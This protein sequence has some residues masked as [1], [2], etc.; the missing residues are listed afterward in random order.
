MGS[1]S[2]MTALE[3]QAVVSSLNPS[4]T[5]PAPLAV[6]TP[7]Q[8][9]NV[10]GAS[11][12]STNCAGC[13]R[14]LG[15]STKV[16]MT[17]ARL[18][19]ATNNNIGG[20]GYLSQLTVTQQ[21][22]IVAVLTPTTPSP[23]TTPPPTPTPVTD[24]ATLYGANCAGCHGVLASSGKAGATTSRI[25]SAIAGNIGNMGYLSTLST[26]QVTAIAAV[27]TT[28]APPSP[29]DGPGLYAANCASCHRSLANSDVR[30]ESASE[31]SEAISE[32]K[33]GMKTLSA[34]TAGMIT[35]IANALK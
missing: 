21:Q 31:I 20:M 28:A 10:D 34:L 15:S 32:N 35:A 2:T 6:T 30:G 33:G 9:Q 13:H 22:A 4:G 26:A 11:L 27:L 14:A 18:Q 19:N 8:S 25:Q 16:G 3:V 5:T 24:G 7:S 12:Y 23:T 29:T 17:L 1:L